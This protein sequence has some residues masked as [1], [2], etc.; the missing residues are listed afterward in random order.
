MLTAGAHQEAAAGAGADAHAARR[1]VFGLVELAVAVLIDARAHLGGRLHRVLAGAGSA[2]GTEGEAAAAEAHTLAAFGAGVAGHLEGAAAF[3]L[4]DGAVAVLI[5][6][7]T[8]LGFGQHRVFTG[9]PPRVIAGLEPRFAA[10]HPHQ[11]GP[12]MARAG[13]PAAVG[14]LVGI[15]VAIVVAAI[16]DFGGALARGPR[17]AGI[18]RGLGVDE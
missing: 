7:V 14:G 15:A 12:R 18:H 3:A 17:I 16:A 5:M 9:Q 8:A 13:Q 1:G 6:P 11:L 2:V 4:V 10:S